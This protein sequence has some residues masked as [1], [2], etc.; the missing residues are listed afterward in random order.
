MRKIIQIS[1]MG[2]EN[3]YET[4]CDYVIIALCNDGTVWE[5]RNTSSEWIQLPS[6]PE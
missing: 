6:L 1:S 5:I 4:Q 2:V 3:V